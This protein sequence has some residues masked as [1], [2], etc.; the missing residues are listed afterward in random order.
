MFVLDALCFMHHE[1][2]VWEALC[3]ASWHTI[4]YAAVFAMNLAGMNSTKVPCQIPPP[5]KQ[6]MQTV[7]LIKPHFKNPRCTGVCRKVVW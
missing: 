7:W 5:P 4:G 3:R 1:R 2:R 6:V